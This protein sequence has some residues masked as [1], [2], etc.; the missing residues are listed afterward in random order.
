MAEQGRAATTV[1]AD[2]AAVM[3]VIADFPSYP[4]WVKQVKRIEVLETGEDGRAQQVQFW[5]DAGVLQDEY[6]L[7]YTWD[8]DRRV[9]WTLVRG[10]QQKAQEGSYTLTPTDGGTHVE[11][12]L[13]VELAVKLPGFL[14]KRA[15]KA[16]MGTA[17]EELKRRVEE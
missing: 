11:Y 4:E 9:D 10:K 17:V 1:A 15:Q 12:E 5:V 16:V 6:V 3:D 14:V 13:M 2:P 7:D 8:G